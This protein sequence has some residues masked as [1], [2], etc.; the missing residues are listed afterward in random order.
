MTG[1]AR[2]RRDGDQGLMSRWLFCDSL[3]GGQR[4]HPVGQGM[5][6][7]GSS[8]MFHVKLHQSAAWGVDPIPRCPDSSDKAPGGKPLRHAEGGGRPVRHRSSPDHLP[9]P[10]KNREHTALRPG[11]P[12]QTPTER[13]TE[14]P[15]QA[16][17][18]LSKTLKMGRLRTGREY[19][20][21]RRSAGR[22]RVL[23]S[24]E[25]APKY[26]PFPRC[27]GEAELRW[28][29]LGAAMRL[30]GTNPTY[31]WRLSFG[32][33]RPVAT[34]RQDIVGGSLFPRLSPHVI[35]SDIHKLIHS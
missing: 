2:T 14:T 9:S 21:L 33:I 28:C 17:D 8:P 11:R 18:N 6:S 19:G 26:E 31:R 3:L 32:D 7:T 30:P 24:H 23:E 29:S 1:T 34:R 12:P 25:A 27:A 35:H 13:S 16:G 4:S 10:L 22:R 15:L 20:G 5:A